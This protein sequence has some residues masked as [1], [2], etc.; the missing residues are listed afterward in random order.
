MGISKGIFRV[1]R[2]FEE[3]N[4]TA[5]VPVR[6]IADF[7]LYIVS[8]KDILAVGVGVVKVQH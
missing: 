5:T 8:D 2:N 1:A 4:R 7:G 3:E 6:S